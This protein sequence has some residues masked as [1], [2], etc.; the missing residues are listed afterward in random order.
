M[1]YFMEFFMEFIKMVII[2]VSIFVAMLVVP[3]GFG[4]YYYEKAS[5]VNYST[6]TGR[7]TAFTFAGGCFVKTEN[8]WLTQDEYGQVI[9]AKEGLSRAR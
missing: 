3:L 4:C 2:P 1:D 6:I 5:C 7:E 9:I 8:S